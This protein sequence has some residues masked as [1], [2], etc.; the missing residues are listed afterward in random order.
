MYPTG[1]VEMKLEPKGA[2]LRVRRIGGAEL[3]GETGTAK[4]AWA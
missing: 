4:L 1:W 2:E 3:P